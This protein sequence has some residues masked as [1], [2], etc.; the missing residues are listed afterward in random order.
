MLTRREVVESH[1]AKAKSALQARAEVL[2]GQK[3]DKKA[4]KRDVSYRRLEAI[5]R[6]YARRVAAFDKVEAV[7]KDLEDRRAE[8]AARANEPK[9]KKQKAK[10]EPKAKAK[11][12]KKA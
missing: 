8:R 4:Q 9:V 3:K 12:S 11:A 2:K 6:K 1:L 7:K 10:P 5:I